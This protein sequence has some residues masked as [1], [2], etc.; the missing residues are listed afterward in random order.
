VLQSYFDVLESKRT[1]WSRLLLLLAYPLIVV[2]GCFVLLMVITWFIMPPFHDMFEDFGVELPALTRITLG[3]STF[4]QDW[5]WAVLLSAGILLAALVA[6]LATLGG[7]ARFRQLFNTLPIVGP[8]LRSIGLARFCKLLAVLVEGEVPLPEAVELA[9]AGS[10]DADLEQGTAEVAAE[11]QAGV[12]LADAASGHHQFPP[13]LVSV[14]R[15]QDRGAAFATTLRD[16]GDLLLVKAQS[17]VGPAAAL[18]GPLMILTVA[19]AVG[20]CLLSLFWPM[21][22]L[23]NELS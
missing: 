13:Q 23:L 10:G 9:G 3:V 19:F 4:L 18:L 17:Q 5:W 14:F 11:L 15:W 16:T 12:L 8:H 2:C 1:M 6:G 22:R 7:A 20:I 21:F